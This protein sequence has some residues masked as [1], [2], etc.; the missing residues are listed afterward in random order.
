RKE[1]S[2][3]MLRQ[4]LNVTDISQALTPEQMITFTIFVVFYIPC[5]ATL[6]ALRKELNTRDMF[7]IATLSVVIAMV[8]A[9]IGRG[10]VILVTSI[11]VII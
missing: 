11:G 7:I 3:I 9:L 2:L 5:L 4:A 1:L 10:L 6:A 8:T